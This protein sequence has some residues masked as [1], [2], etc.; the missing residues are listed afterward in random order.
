MAN[1]QPVKVGDT[2]FSAQDGDISVTAKVTR[3]EDDEYWAELQFMGTHSAEEWH[4]NTVN[5]NFDVFAFGVW[6]DGP[7]LPVWWGDIDGDGKPELLAPLPKGDLS[8][9][10][11]RIFRWT[12]E[13]LLFLKKRAL[14]SA[15]KGTF[16]WAQL[17]DE[18]V[19]T[20]WVESFENGRAEV[21]SLKD[22]HLERELIDF[23]PT[24]EGIQR[25]GN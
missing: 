20:D 18:A 17:G 11:F 1:L 6:M 13:D 16:A 22:G 12:G 5:D 9:P 25:T 3:F 14:V 15:G 24:K 19:E 10:I 2:V 21:L 7:G 23:K 4:A 8:P